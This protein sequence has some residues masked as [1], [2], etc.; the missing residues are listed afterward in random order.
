M[1][2]KTERWAGTKMQRVIL[3]KR[4]TFLL[5]VGVESFPC[6]ISLKVYKLQFPIS[7]K[8]SFQ[9]KRNKTVAVLTFTM[10]KSYHDAPTIL[11]LYRKGHSPP[12]LWVTDL[13]GERATPHY[14]RIQ[15]QHNSLERTGGLVTQTQCLSNEAITRLESL[16]RQCPKAANDSPSRHRKALHSVP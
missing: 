1:G 5:Y 4:P 9:D 6:A 8:S 11:I 14:C 12:V 10:N 16:T 7:I 15:V 2:S 3:L 13:G